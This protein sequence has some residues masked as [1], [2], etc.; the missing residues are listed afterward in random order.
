MDF[1]EVW[2]EYTDDAGQTQRTKILSRAEGTLPQTGNRW[3]TATADLSPFAGREVV[4]QF[5]FDTGD[6]PLVDPEGWYVDDVVVASL[7]KAVC[8]FKWQD[9]NHNGVWDE[10]EPGLNGT[11]IYADTDGSGTFNPAQEEQTFYGAVDAS[12]SPPANKSAM[13]SGSPRCRCRRPVRRS[14]RC[15]VPPR[16]PARVM[17]MGHGGRGRDL[18]V[19]QKLRVE[20]ESGYIPCRWSSPQRSGPESQRTDR[21]GSLRPQPQPHRGTFLV[22][23]DTELADPDRITV[24]NGASPTVKA[25]VDYGSVRLNNLQY[26][27][28]TAATEGDPWVVTGNDGRHDGAFRSSGC[29]PAPTCSA[30]SC[31]KAGSKPI[32]APGILP[33]R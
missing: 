29:R 31:R 17:R 5:S 10:G 16:P 1:V 14:G 27:G 20:F 21:A 24:G 18:A 30:K 13:P 8:G 25:T 11:T 19:G 12:D 23:S 33:I 7:P 28:T 4:V 6:V 2:V 9:E 15:R 32:P 22:Q 3:L 26:W